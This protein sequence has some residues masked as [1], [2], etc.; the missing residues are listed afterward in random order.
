MTFSGEKLKSGIKNFIM[1][2]GSTVNISL[3][4]STQ[5][6]YLKGSSEYNEY[7][8]AWQSKLTENE[9]VVTSVHCTITN[10]LFVC[11]DETLYAVGH[12]NTMNK[13]WNSSYD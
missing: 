5:F 3:A 12:P 9:A 7:K 8:C 6:K 13:C 10:T 4:P 11:E 2:R 1:D